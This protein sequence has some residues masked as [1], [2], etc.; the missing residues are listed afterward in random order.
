[1]CVWYYACCQLTHYRNGVQSMCKYCDTT[2]DTVLID[3]SIISGEDEGI[4]ISLDAKL[5][6]LCIDAQYD[7]G[8]LCD[9]MTTH[10]NYCPMC[11]RK[12]RG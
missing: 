5:G 4:A 11:G 6:E 9:F 12:L 10:V 7:S 2:K 8:C 1:M 3:S